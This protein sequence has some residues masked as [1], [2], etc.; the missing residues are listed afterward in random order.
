M[1]KLLTVLVLALSLAAYSVPVA[2][3]AESHY[4]T[5][6]STA[7][8]DSPSAPRAMPIENDVTA[9]FQVTNGAGTARMRVDAN[10]TLNAQN[11]NVISVNSVNVYQNGYSLNFVSWET[12]R[13]K[14]FL[15]NPQ[16]GWISLE[17]HGHVTFSAGTP[18]PFI[19]IGDSTNVIKTVQIAC[20]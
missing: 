14:T 13:V 1:K 19:N 9:S 20:D 6:V 8:K 3:A 4:D 12:T 11:S 2:L 7:T 17:I 16:N 10:V 15:N 5:S 18:L